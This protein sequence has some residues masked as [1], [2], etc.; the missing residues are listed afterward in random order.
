MT[1][2]LEELDD[3]QIDSI[4]ENLKQQKQKDEEE[5]ISKAKEDRHKENA[6]D[7]FLNMAE[8]ALNNDTFQDAPIEEQAGVNTLF[9]DDDDIAA[10]REAE[11]NEAQETSDKELPM[12]IKRQI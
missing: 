6:Q 10:R 11:K 7:D 5:A 2:N 3:A 8:D 4:I 12:A 1:G 9:D